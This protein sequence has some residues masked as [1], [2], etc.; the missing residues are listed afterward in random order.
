MRAQTAKV[1]NGVVQRGDYVR[2]YSRPDA[3]DK[4]HWQRAPI[5]RVLIVDD[6]SSGGNTGTKLRCRPADTNKML[7]AYNECRLYA[8]N[9]MKVKHEKK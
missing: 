1:I 3:R 2:L 5:G 6:I 8:C 4:H 7:D 9:A